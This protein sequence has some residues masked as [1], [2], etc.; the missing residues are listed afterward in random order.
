MIDHAAALAIEVAH[1]AVPASQVVAGSPSTGS[2]SL[3][4]LDG[5]EYGVWEMTPGAMRDVEADELFVVL[6]GEARLDLVDDG[7]TLMLSAGS[8]ARL[9]AGMHT[10]WTVVE[11]LRKVYVTPAAG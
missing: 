6:F 2:V 9:S 1:T 10:V 5:Q 3:G 8:V 11:T 4:E 7:T